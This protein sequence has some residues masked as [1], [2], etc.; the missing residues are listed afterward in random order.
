M[1]NEKTCLFETPITILVAGSSK[2]GK[3]YWV[4]KLVEQAGYIFCH[5]PKRIIWSYGK[6]CYQKEIAERLTKQYK[7]KIKFREGFPQEEIENGTLFKKND[8]GILILDDLLMEV[9]NNKIFAKIFLQFS[10]H[11]KF[12]VIFLTQSLYNSEDRTNP[13]VMRNCDIL[14]CLLIY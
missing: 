13:V 12:S 9:S 4:V 14:V 3:T 5:K 8:N 10:H 2:V 11:Q 1:N 7:N 6:G